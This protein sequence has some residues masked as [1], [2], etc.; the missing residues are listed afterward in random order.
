MVQELIFV[1]NDLNL[2]LPVAAP[3]TVPAKKTGRQVGPQEKPSFHEAMYREI[4]GKQEVKLSAHAEKRLRERNITLAQEDLDKIN[5]AVKEAASKGARESLII[6][7][8][9]ALITNIRN[10]TIVTAMGGNQGV[11]QVFTNIDSA[12]IVG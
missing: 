6:Y 10:N 9:L 3:L 4:T 7:E 8:G 12:V 5:A 11:S 1:N 2:I